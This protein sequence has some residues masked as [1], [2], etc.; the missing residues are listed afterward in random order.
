MP[1]LPPQ[2]LKLDA[3]QGFGRVALDLHLHQAKMEF[4]SIS[5]VD[6][7]ISWVPCNPRET[8]VL[9]ASTLLQ[10]ASDR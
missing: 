9:G 1:R 4:P 6:L 2:P 3:L 7:E 10:E 8:L 5:L